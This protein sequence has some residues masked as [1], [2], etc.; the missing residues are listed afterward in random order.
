MTSNITSLGIVE[1]I[2][3]LGKNLG[4]TIT[5]EGIENR[6]QL[7]LIKKMKCDFVQGYFTGKPVPASEMTALLVRQIQGLV[8]DTVQ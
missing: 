3:N 2:I 6:D 7:H 8:P 5:A 4:L 1:S